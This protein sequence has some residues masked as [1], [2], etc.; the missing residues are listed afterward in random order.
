M[1]GILTTGGRPERLVTTESL[2]SRA[3]HHP[4]HRHHVVQLYRSEFDAICNHLRQNDL[5]KRTAAAHTMEDTASLPVLL[6]RQ[7]K[8]RMSESDCQQLLGR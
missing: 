8:G 4:R 2:K 7:Y 5:Q 6:F 1:V 3:G